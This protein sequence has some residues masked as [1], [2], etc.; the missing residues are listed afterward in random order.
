MSLDQVSAHNLSDIVHTFQCP[1]C[2]QTIVNNALFK[3]EIAGRYQDVQ[4][5]A[6]IF[7]AHNLKLTE[8]KTILID[9][10]EDEDEDASLTEIRKA[11]SGG[12]KTPLTNT[13]LSMFEAIIKIYQILAE[14]THLSLMAQ[15]VENTK[16]ISKA[17]IKEIGQIR[18]LY[19]NVEAFKEIEEVKIFSYESGLIMQ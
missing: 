19:Q 11:L 4:R 15:A 10:L 6:D 8:R 2:S 9:N 18:K 1:A 12:L 3:D 7:F 5:L 17:K 13:D 14:H 16:I